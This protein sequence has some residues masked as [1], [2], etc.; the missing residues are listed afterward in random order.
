MKQKQKSVMVLTLGFEHVSAMD[1][2]VILVPLLVGRSLHSAAEHLTYLLAIDILTRGIAAYSESFMSILLGLRVKPPHLSSPSDQ[3][4]DYQIPLLFRLLDIRCIGGVNC[5]VR[6]LR[7]G[8][9]I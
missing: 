7:S 4:T 6:P 3:K 9:F 8:F 1:A 5:K 2:E